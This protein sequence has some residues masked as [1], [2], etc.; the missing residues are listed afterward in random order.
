MRLASS[1]DPKVPL[2]LG[3]NLELEHLPIAHHSNCCV[4]VVT[5]SVGSLE[6]VPKVALKEYMLSSLTVG[7]QG[8]CQNAISHP[9]LDIIFW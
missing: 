4:A 3:C 6:I 2:A 7:G 8:L 9:V 5:V 1:S